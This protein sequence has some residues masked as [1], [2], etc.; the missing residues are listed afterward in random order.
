MGGCGCGN[1]KDSAIEIVHVPHGTNMA[2]PCTGSRNMFYAGLIKAARKAN[3]DLCAIEFNFKMK[4]QQNLITGDSD[5]KAYLAKPPPHALQTNIVNQDD[6]LDLIEQNLR[7]YVV[8]NL[9]DKHK[10]AGCGYLLTASIVLTYIHVHGEAPLD[11]YSQDE[12]IQKL[13]GVRGCP[14]VLKNAPM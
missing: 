12:D 2:K 6:L 3:V 14:R 13:L 8:K 5:L 9:D 7:N 11:S 1:Q 10:I 4:E